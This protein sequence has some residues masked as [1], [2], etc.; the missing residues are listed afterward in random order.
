MEFSSGGGGRK[1][2]LGTPNGGNI[3]S[4][5]NFSRGSNP[6]FEKS[7]PSLFLHLPVTMFPQC[8]DMTSVVGDLMPLCVRP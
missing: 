5:F 8:E 3:L 6:R 4:I 2:G 7:Q 1:G